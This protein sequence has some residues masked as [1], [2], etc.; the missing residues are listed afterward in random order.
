MSDRGGQEVRCSTKSDAGNRDSVILPSRSGRAHGPSTSAESAYKFNTVG[1]RS[2]QGVGAHH[3]STERLDVQSRLSPS[4]WRHRREHARR[5]NGER[6]GP[7]CR[8]QHPPH[9]R[10]PKS[11]QPAP[12]F[13]GRIADASGVKAKPVS[14]ADYKGKVVVL[15]FY[16]GDRTSGCT[17]ELRSSA[18]STPPCSATASSCS[19]SRSDSL[20]SHASWASEMK[21][22]FALISDP[23]LSIAGQVRLGHPGPEVCLAHGL[24]RRQGRQPPIPRAQV[25]RVER[26]RV[27]EARRRS[28]EGEELGFVIREASAEGYRRMSS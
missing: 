4:R 8:P 15:A 12:N 23:D 7:G 16:P 27:Q 28:R 11:G 10:R 13:T 3:P 6:P 26:G 21:F 14:L 22:P 18:T 24:R 19:A 1:R 17:A 5:S 25:R 9:R 20:A 2:Y